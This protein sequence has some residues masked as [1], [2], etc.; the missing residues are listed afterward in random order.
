M[1]KSSTT[2]NS[3]EIMLSKR[4]FWY[5]FGYHAWQVI[6]KFGLWV[7]IATA[8]GTSVNLIRTGKIFGM[9][10]GELGVAFLKPVPYVA[11]GFVTAVV[12]YGVIRGLISTLSTKYRL[13]PQGV[14]LELGWMNRTTTLVSFEQIQR[15]TIVSNP[16][17][18]ML[19]ASY[20]NLDL[21]GGANA[22]QLEAIDKSAV[23]DLYE[24][25]AASRMQAL[26]AVALQTL[27]LERK[28][29]E[30]T[31][32]RSVVKAEKAQTTKKKSTSAKARKKSAAA[33]SK[34]KTPAKKPTRSRTKKNATSKRAAT[35]AARQS[36]P[37]TA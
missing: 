8:A 36:Q 3:S 28:L 22:I 21:I 37:I 27:E 33:G 16:Y 34:K 32:K 1:A 25:L 11:A 20:I 26:Q 6:K 10:D 18:R 15:M 4:A 23:E 9:S 17:D 12:L 31:S 13:T 19:K 30:N 14:M 7:V 35:R 24:V 29:I 2:Q 5:F